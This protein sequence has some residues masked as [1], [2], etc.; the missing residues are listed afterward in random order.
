LEIVNADGT[1]SAMLRLPAGSR[2]SALAWTQAGTLVLTDERRHAV[3]ELDRTGQELRRIGQPGLGRAEFFKPRGIAIDASGRWWILDAGNHRVQILSP[4]GEFVHAFGSRL[5][6]DPLRKGHTPSQP[7]QWTSWPSISSAQHRFR[8]HFQASRW[9]PAVG[10]TLSVEAHLV[11][12]A[13]LSQEPALVLDGGMPEHGHGLAR[14]TRAT[15]LGDFHWKFEGLR[16][17]MGGRWRLYFD[18]RE[19]ARTERAEWEVVLE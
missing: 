9:P 14:E 2:P 16:L 13:E 18:I 8:V 11:P 12:L 5:F 17:H 4:Q 19:G 1:S 7:P 6:T 3:L 15:R 10:E